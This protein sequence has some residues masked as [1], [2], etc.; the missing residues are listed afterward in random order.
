MYTKIHICLE[1]SEYHN[2]FSRL[3]LPYVL[4]LRSTFTFPYLVIYW[5]LWS[6]FEI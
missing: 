2:C 1:K 3:R 6:L 5:S 4:H